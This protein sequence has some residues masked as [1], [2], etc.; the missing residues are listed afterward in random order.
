MTCQ[1]I[2]KV[3]VDWWVLPRHTSY[4]LNR[5]SSS[6]PFMFLLGE[7]DEDRTRAPPSSKA[8]NKALHTL[9]E[10]AAFIIWLVIY[11]SQVYK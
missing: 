6:L 7:N 9:L 8:N 5:H 4:P 10:Y 1:C 3:G 11:I 2:N